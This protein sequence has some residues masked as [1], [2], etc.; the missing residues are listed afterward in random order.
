MSFFCPV[1][2]DRL[3]SF[4]ES[5]YGVDPANR[6]LDQTI[7]SAHTISPARHAGQSPTQKISLV[8]RIE[9]KN[10]TCRIPYHALQVS[11]ICK[12]GCQFCRVDELA[13]RFSCTIM[14]KRVFV[15]SVQQ[16]IKPVSQKGRIFPC[17]GILLS[18]IIDFY[19]TLYHVSEANKHK[20][21]Q[22]LA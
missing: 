3:Y 22:G 11:L 12:C 7:S 14:F 5:G 4:L 21:R 9:P 2:Y 16:L 8:I 15:S 10:A 1:M 17:G 19:H 20:H 13:L 6:S 18:T